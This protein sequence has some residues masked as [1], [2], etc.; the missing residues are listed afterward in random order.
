MQD[1]LFCNIVAGRLPAEILYQDHQVVVFKDIHPQAPVHL[2]IIP[3]KHIESLLDVSQADGELMAELLLRTQAIAQ[4][5]K[6]A[7]EGFRLVVNTGRNAG[8]A[9]YHLHLHLLGGRRLKWPPG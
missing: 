7:Q 9:V 8:Q 3:V 1:C 5:L 4:E 2:L 6:L